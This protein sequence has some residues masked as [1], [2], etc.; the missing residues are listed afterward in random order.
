MN[1]SL[2]PSV[3]NIKLLLQLYTR[4]VGCP[5]QLCGEVDVFFMQLYGL[6]G[7]RLTVAVTLH[8]C[9]DVHACL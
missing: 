7:L 2:G 1:D 3:N 9:A 4:N 5:L 6:I 8:T